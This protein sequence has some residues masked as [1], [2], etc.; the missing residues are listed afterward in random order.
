MPTA[1]RLGLTIFLTIYARPLSAPVRRELS[2]FRVI[3]GRARTSIGRWALPISGIIRGNAPTGTPRL[4]MPVIIC[5]RSQIRKEVGDRPRRRP[6]QGGL[7]CLFSWPFAHAPP[8]SPRNLA[9]CFRGPPEQATIPGGK[10]FLFRDH[11]RTRPIFDR[12]AVDIFRDY[13]QKIP[14]VGEAGRE[15]Q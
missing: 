4:D 13:P 3:L 6:Q 1:A 10:V 9:L 5:G 15:S 14:Q 11:T 8:E 2:I 7:A 12:P